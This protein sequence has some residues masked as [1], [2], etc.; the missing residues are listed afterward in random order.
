MTWVEHIQPTNQFVIIQYP[1]NSVCDSR[2]PHNQRVQWKM[3]FVPKIDDFSHETLPDKPKTAM[4]GYKLSPHVCKFMIWKCSWLKSTIFLIKW[5]SCSTSVFEPKAP[6]T[7][8]WSA[9]GSSPGKFNFRTP[10]KWLMSTT[11]DMGY[12]LAAECPQVSSQFFW[13]GYHV[14]TF[15]VMIEPIISQKRFCFHIISQNNKDLIV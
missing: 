6:I 8:C 2:F 5:K 9:A 4:G 11:N 10:D 12:P 14:F 15:P 1:K 3:R 7:K 13:T